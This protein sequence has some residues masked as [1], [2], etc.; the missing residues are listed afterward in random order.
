MSE[1][2]INMGKKTKTETKAPKK[3]GFKWWILFIILALICGAIVFGVYRIKHMNV[4]YEKTIP[5][6][7][8]FKKTSNV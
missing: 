5:A 4:D 2:Q 7:A 1:G 3:K 6:P 8:S